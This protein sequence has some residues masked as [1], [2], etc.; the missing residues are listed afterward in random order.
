MAVPSSGTLSLFNIAKEMELNNYSNTIPISTYNS[1]YATPISL[2]NMSTGAGG[3][4]AINTSNSS[5]NRPNGSVPH[6]MSEFYAY[7]HDKVSALA[8]GTITTGVDNYYSSYFYGYSDA[9]F[10]DM[11]SASTGLTTNSFGSVT[12]L[13]WQNSNYLYVAFSST[14]PTFSGLSINGQSQGGS[15]SFSSYNSTTWRKYTTSN[16]FGTS[17]NTIISV[18]FT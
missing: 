14:K 3:F 6:N 7:D 10:P 12:G 8:S 13:Y 11:G 2:G 4:D 16:P 15:S 5:S 1:Y 18:V 9:Y 17:S